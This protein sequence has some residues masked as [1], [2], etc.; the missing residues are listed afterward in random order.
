MKMDPVIAEIRAVREAHAA[1]F[2]GD[3]RAM[4]ADLRKRQRES[5]RKSVLRP[6]K[7]VPSSVRKSE[8]ASATHG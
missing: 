2:G 7:R 4:L 8:A 3:V 1:K 5:G 6:A